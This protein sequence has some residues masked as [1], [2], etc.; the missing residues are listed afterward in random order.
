MKFSILL[1][2]NICHPYY[3]LKKNEFI[4]NIKNYEIYEANIKYNHFIPRHFFKTNKIHIND[5][6]S[7]KNEKIIHSLD[8]IFNKNSTGICFILYLDVKI[9]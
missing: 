7:T 9:F 8:F 2:H 5:K 4:N 3:E 1:L 6:L